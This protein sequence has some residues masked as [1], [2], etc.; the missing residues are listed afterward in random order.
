MKYVF[1]DKWNTWTQ[2]SVQWNL[3]SQTTAMRDHLSW[4]TTTSRQKDRQFNRIDPVT[5]DPYLE[6]SSLEVGVVFQGRFHCSTT[7]GTVRTKQICT[8]YGVQYLHKT[9]LHIR[10]LHKL[11][12]TICSSL[13][14]YILYTNIANATETP[15]HRQASASHSKPTTIS[16]DLMPPSVIWNVWHWS[17][18]TTEEPDFCLAT[19]KPSQCPNFDRIYKMWPC[20]L[21][22]LIIVANTSLSCGVP[23]FCGRTGQD[24]F[25]NWLFRLSWFSYNKHTFAAFCGASHIRL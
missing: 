15:K 10:C 18:Q 6:T 9:I 8:M 7:A 4:K 13:G 12:A 5:R 16:T 14:S 17:K 23:L 1:S 21:Q 11:N 19:L 2:I 3:S 22:I 25:K 24:L 20:T